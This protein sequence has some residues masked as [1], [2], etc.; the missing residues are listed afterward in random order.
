LL[1]LCG[2]I[3][4]QL[5]KMAAKAKSSAAKPTKSTKKAGKRSRKGK[6][7]FK[8]Y[9]FK[10]LKAVHKDLTLSGKTMGILNSFV[11]D[12]FERI[13]TEASGLARVNKRR[14]LGSREVQTAVRLLLPAELAKHAIAEG[15]KAV[16]KASA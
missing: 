3:A 16:A 7:T 8:R 13:A 15:T 11:T 9:I 12:M 1:L 6:R 4:K 5:N 2:K 14:T 10:A